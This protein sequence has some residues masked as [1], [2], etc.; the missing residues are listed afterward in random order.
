MKPRGTRLER[1]VRVA[2]AAFAVTLLLLW[3]V[4]GDRMAGALGFL[5]LLVLYLFAVQ[6]VGEP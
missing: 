4:N 6:R 3:L 1:V 2:N 5:C